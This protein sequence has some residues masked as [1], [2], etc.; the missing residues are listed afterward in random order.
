ML[1]IV[2]YQSP[3][4]VADD[5]VSKQISEIINSII[6]EEK[7]IYQIKDFEELRSL[8]LQLELDEIHKEIIGYNE[9]GIQR[10]TILVKFIK[11]HRNSTASLLAYYL[12]SRDLEDFWKESFLSERQYILEEIIKN[13]SDEIICNVAAV[14]LFK[15]KYLANRNQKEK[16]QLLNN[17]INSLHSLL[18]IVDDWYINNPKLDIIKIYWYKNEARP[19]EVSFELHIKMELGAMYEELGDTKSAI[20]IYSEIV[21]KFKGTDIAKKAQSRI[22]LLKK[23]QIEF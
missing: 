3:K 5:M 11:M 9:L 14:D 7:L 23:T 19:L 12:I 22:E 17:Y 4:I 10:I 1:I 2:L 16:R 8:I 13:Q 20:R 21:A 15:Q 6:I 18:Q